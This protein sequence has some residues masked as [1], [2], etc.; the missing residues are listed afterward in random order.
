MNL[1]VHFWVIFGV[2]VNNLNANISFCFHISSL[3]SR[4]HLR[5]IDLALV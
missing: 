2:Y 5:L 3:G 4:G 1:F